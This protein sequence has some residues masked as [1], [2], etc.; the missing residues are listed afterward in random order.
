MLH[1]YKNGIIFKGFQRQGSGRLLQR[2][3]I[4]LYF[5]IVGQFK[6]HFDL[7]A[8]AAVAGVVHQV[9]KMIMVVKVEAQLIDERERLLYRVLY[10]QFMMK[11]EFKLFFFI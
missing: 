10:I 6:G 5:R 9:A 2:T 11:M 8:V 1:L 7:D 4:L 3:E